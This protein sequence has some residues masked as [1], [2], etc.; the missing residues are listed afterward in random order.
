MAVRWGEGTTDKVVGAQVWASE[1]VFPESMENQ[2]S[3]IVCSCHSSIALGKWEVEIG[4][5]QGPASLVLADTEQ[6]KARS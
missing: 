2:V 1:F 6:Q 3:Y 4:E 5:P